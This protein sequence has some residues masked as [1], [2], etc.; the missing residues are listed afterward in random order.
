[1]WLKEMGVVRGQKVQYE[2]VE[3]QCCEQGTGV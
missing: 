1:V 3:L 2:A